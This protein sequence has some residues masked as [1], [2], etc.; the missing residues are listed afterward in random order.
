MAWL[1]ALISSIVAAIGDS[2]NVRNYSWF[3]VA[4]MF[5]CI[6]GVFIVI[7]SNTLATYRVAIVGFLAAAIILCSSATDS[8]IYT[9][10]GA[11]E[12]ASAGHMLLTMVAV[13]RHLSIVLPPML[14]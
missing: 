5:C 6:V 1:I 4:Y 8:L 10:N 14:M 3:A 12:A 7:A 2:H 11:K 13:S 9:S